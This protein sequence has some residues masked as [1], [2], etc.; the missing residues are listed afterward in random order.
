MIQLGLIEY[1][2]EKC[3]EFLKTSYQI[4]QDD[5]FFSEKRR[6]RKRRSKGHYRD[7]KKVMISSD[8]TEGE[9]VPLNIQL[10]KLPGSILNTI[11]EREDY[12]PMEE[13]NEANY[14]KL[15]SLVN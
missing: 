14:L 5:C 10:P 12:S 7:K 13:I 9:I 3:D 1:A 15:V 2:L 11:E 8:E 6:R 4:I